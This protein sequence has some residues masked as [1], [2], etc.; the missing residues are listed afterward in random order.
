[1]RTSWARGVFSALVALAAFAG[2]L[3]VSRPLAESV[4]LSRL[5]REQSASEQPAAA[6]AASPP[7]PVNWLGRIKAQ[8]KRRLPHLPES[9]RSHLAQ[10]I[11]DE[12][13]LA[14]LDPLMVLAIIAVESG[15]NSDATSERGALGLMQLKPETFAHEAER[16]GLDE[17]PND[18]DS[19]IRAGVRYYRRL[20]RAFNRSHELALMA[21][22]AGPARIR[23][24]LDS[25]E[26]PERFW[27]YPQRVR[28]ELK[29]MKGDGTLQ[30]H[31]TPVPVP[32]AQAPTVAEPPA[33]SGKAP[34]AVSR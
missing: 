27:I 32:P 22:N 12:A 26:V 24:Y 6:P 13:K 10:V 7:A 28:S 19:N 21:Y 16:S 2:L 8:L 20:F 15:F 34:L 23:E 3:V 33:L 30:S 25:G 9:D 31:P 29:R 1:M 5:S 11:V 17:D 18:P 14:E 4:D